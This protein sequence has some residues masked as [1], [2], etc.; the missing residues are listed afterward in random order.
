MRMSRLSFAVIL[1]LGAGACGDGAAV[2]VPETPVYDGGTLGPG[3]RTPS[4]TTVITSAEGGGTLGPGGRA[5]EGEGSG[6]SGEE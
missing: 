6:G 2:T 5:A 1:V 4:D 3:G